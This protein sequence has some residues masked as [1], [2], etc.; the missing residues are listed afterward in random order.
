MPSCRRYGKLKPKHTNPRES[1]EKRMFNHESIQVTMQYSKFRH[2]SKFS[3]EML[4][5]IW[6]PPQNAAECQCVGEGARR[7]RFAEQ[8][9][10]EG[11]GEEHQEEH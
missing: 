1:Q 8:D 11:V 9:G 5:P 3:S 4:Q 6:K 10:K 2:Q 7:A